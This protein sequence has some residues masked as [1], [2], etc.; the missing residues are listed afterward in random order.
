MTKT[1]LVMETNADIFKLN[2]NG[3]RTDGFELDNAG[4]DDGHWW[5][6]L[7]KEDEQNE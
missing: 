1:E 6:I 4:Y 5:A 2:V 3:Y 7:K